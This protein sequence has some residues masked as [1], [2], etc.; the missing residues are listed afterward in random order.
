MTTALE[1]VRG[2]P[3]AP[4]DFYPRERPGT[5]CIEGWVDPKAG[6]DRCRKSRP[7]LGFD[8][9]TVQPV[10]SRYTDY[11]NRPIP[12]PARPVRSQLLY[13]LSYPDHFVYTVS[14]ITIK[15]HNYSNIIALEY[16]QQ[17]SGCIWE[18]HIEE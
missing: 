11:A 9:R 14:L 4:A 8:P 10:V 18:L 2:Q 3:H 1:G 12:S 7:P 15:R 17:S 13:R 6:L 16:D 5:R